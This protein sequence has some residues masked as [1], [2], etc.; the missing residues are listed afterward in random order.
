MQGADCDNKSSTI[1]YNHY[2]VIK[3]QTI[4]DKSTKYKISSMGPQS[5]WVK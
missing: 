1:L 3:V 4:K 5:I 2:P